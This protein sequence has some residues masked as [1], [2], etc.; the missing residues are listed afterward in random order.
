M[1]EVIFKISVLFSAYFD[2]LEVNHLSFPKQRKGSGFLYIFRARNW[3]FEH[4]S[5]SNANILKEK[6]KGNLI[7]FCT[8]EPE[9]MLIPGVD[10]YL[11]C[12]CLL[13]L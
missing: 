7:K 5:K 1:L 13:C 2:W 3:S 9:Q 12:R 8:R 6:S 10:V 4:S 11:Q